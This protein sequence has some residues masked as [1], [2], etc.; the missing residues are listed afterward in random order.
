MKEYLTTNQKFWN[1]KYSAPNVESFAF[2]LK[3]KLLDKYIPQ[4][5][6]LK[7]LEFGC[8]EGSNMNY[9]IKTYKYDGYGVD[10]SEESIRVCKKKINQKKF[11]LINPKPS[12]DDIFFDKKFDL[13]VSFEVLYYLSNEDLKNRLISLNN[14]L[15]PKGFVFF[16]MMGTKNEYFKFFS[17]KRKNKLGLTKVDLG[18]DKDYRR[19]QKHPIYYHYINFTKNERELKKKFKIFKPLNIGFYDQSLENNYRN[20]FHFTFLGQKK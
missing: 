12:K 4:N 6:K 5:K 3:S 20:G 16:T 18:V 19:R 7:I 17:S 13:V 15:K 9:F 10:I 8:G 14:M 1:R 11:K 2:R